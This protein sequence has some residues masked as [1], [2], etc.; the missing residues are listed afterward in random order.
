MKQLVLAPDETPSSA[1]DG[2]AAGVQ[3][4]STA[5][6][7]QVAPPIYPPI[8]G[9]RARETGVA[10]NLMSDFVDMANSEGFGVVM[11]LGEFMSW[12]VS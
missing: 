7:Y 6:V 1:T 12:I 10:H 9:V 8:A 3:G 2:C 4:P 11:N 5:F